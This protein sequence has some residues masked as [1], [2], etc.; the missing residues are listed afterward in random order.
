MIIMWDRLYRLIC[1][2]QSEETSQEFQK[3]TSIHA[4]MRWWWESYRECQFT[5]PAIPKAPLQLHPLI[6][7]P[8][9]RIAMDL[10]RPLDHN[11]Q[12]YQF[13]TSH[14]RLCNSVRSAPVHSTLEF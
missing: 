1:D 8:F 14:R 10:I 5:T 9:E 3:S 7:N 4:D 13:S 12:G 6:E 2:T 11:A